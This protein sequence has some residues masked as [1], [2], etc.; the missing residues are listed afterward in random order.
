[1]ARLVHY[2]HE[3]AAMPSKGDFEWTK[4][5]GIYMLRQTLKGDGKEV[6]DTLTSNFLSK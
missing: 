3:E 5:F 2:R 6:W 1:M 4:G